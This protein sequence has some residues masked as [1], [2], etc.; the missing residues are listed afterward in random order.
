MPRINQLFLS[1]NYLSVLYCN[2]KIIK[3]VKYLIAGGSAAV[4]NLF[5]LYV[6]TEGFHVWYLY[7]AIL[8]FFCAL[9]FSFSLQKLWTFQDFSA[10]KISNQAFLYSVIAL[11]NLLVNTSIL[12]FLVEYCRIWYLFSQIIAGLMVA[13]Y[14]FF[15]YNFVIFKRKI[16]FEEIIN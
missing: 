3:I 10:K 2:K 5:I 4:V 15:I 12:Y 8:A 6:L 9:G 13:S 7:S 14:S 16:K 11:F 1:M